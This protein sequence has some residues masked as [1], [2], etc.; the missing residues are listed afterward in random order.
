MQR[1]RVLLYL[2][3]LAASLAYLS[4][5]H[6]ADHAPGVTP[7][8]ERLMAPLDDAYIFGQYARQALKGEWLHYTPGAPISTG[9][10]SFSWLLGLTALMGL[11]CH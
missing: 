2:A 4:A 6:A 8:A 1:S 5:W 3:V 7:S 11:G 9:V 10:S